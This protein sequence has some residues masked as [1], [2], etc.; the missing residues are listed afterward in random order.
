LSSPRRTYRKSLVSVLTF[1]RHT[2]AVATF[3]LVHGAWHGAWCWEL[4]IP[5]LER[6]GHSTATMD[7]PCEDRN[8]TFFDYADAVVTA[9]GTATDVVLVGHSMAGITVPLVA[10]K[11]PIRL[12]VF[13]CALVPDRVDDANASGPATHPEGA[14]DALMQHEDGSHSWPTVEAATRILYQDCDPRL[15]A[16][17]FARL[18]RQ[19]TALWDRLPPSEHWPNVPNASIHCR[20]DRAINP[21]WSR[22]VA[23]KRLGVD[24][25]EVPG[26]HSPMLSRP[27]ALADALIAVANE[28]STRP[29]GG[30]DG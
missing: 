5:L 14:F 20:D 1:S 15:A 18:R 17:A 4:L 9:L 22:W 26:G 7:L 21:S 30:R 29:Q 23:L 2:C 13:L 19:Q 10:L 28:R 11:R 16:N 8:A 3:G 27:A 6:R 12:M 25:L 24:S